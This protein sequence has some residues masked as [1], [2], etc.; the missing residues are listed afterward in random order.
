MTSQQSAV[1]NQRSAISGQRSGFLKRLCAESRTLNA[2][3]LNEKGIALVMV[4]ILSLIAFAIISALIY[5]LTQSTVV[6]AI[7]KRYRTALEASHGGVEFT[8]KEI[9]PQTIP[10]T[11]LS[12]LGTYAGLMSVQVTDACFAAKLTSLPPNWP[13]GCSSTLDPKPSPDITLTLLGVPPQ[14]NFNVF[15]KVVD[16]ALGNSDRSGLEL[17]GLG[18]VESGAG[19]IT[20]K[21]SPY[22]YRIELQAERAGTP[23]ERSNLSALYAY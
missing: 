15:V 12:S 8:T 1:S 18:V 23:D 3:V 22:I 19:M 7:Q 20:P 21:H 9:I 6:S 13:G 2:R 14:P 4:L 11:T 10:G 17:E 5:F 16:T